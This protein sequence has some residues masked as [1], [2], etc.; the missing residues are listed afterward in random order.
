M[1]RGKFPGGPGART[2]LSLMKT[3]VQSLVDE[4]K[5]HK[6]HGMVEKR[7]KKL[8]RREL[9][10][11]GFPGGASGKEPT[12]QCRR[13]SRLGLIPGLGR[14]PG[15]RHGNPLQYSCLE[16]PMDRQTW[17]AAVHR[18]EKS[19]TWLQQ[20]SMQHTQNSQ[21]RKVQRRKLRREEKLKKYKNY[22]DWSKGVSETLTLS[23]IFLEEWSLNH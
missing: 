11:R 6:Q 15:R 20:L 16:N 17:Q 18:V 14:S 23:I 2:L 10:R 22:G 3:R 7:K 9:N 12:C 19:Q 8:M 13:L 5:S 1:R 21:K 4:L